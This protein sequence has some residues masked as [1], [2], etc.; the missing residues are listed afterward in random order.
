VIAIAIARK[1]CAATTTYAWID[2][3][4]QSTGSW[5][6]A[7]LVGLALSGCSDDEHID[8]PVSIETAGRAG[9]V[10]AV[11]GGSDGSAGTTASS[12]S[13]NTKADAGMSRLDASASAD[14]AG[15]NDQV[16]FDAVY[17]TIVKR[18]C[19]ACHAGDRPTGSLDMSSAVGAYAALVGA[20][21]NPGGPCSQLGIHRVE[22]HAPDR[23]LLYLKLS[24][25]HVPCGQ[26]MPAGGELRPEL[27]RLIEQWIAA[28][29]QKD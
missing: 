22:P 12:A 7:V 18:F 20:P 13:G 19:I 5:S 4:M 26:Q 14:D 3:P 16:T 24:T 8:R 10:T 21:A 27:Q 11:V 2:R 28:G 25:Q 17:E 29:A 6:A 15:S 1:I 23:S 9:D